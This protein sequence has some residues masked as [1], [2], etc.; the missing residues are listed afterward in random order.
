MSGCKQKLNG[1]LKNI[2]AGHPQQWYLN[3]RAEGLTF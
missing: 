1:H 3:A 2:T